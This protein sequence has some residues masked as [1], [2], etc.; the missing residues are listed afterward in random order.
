MKKILSVVLLCILLMLA[1]TGCNISDRYIVE[2]FYGVVK[3]SYI[4]ERLV[5][6]IPNIGDVEI[7]KSEMT[8]KCFDVQE[9]E[10]DYQLKAGDYVIINFRYERSWDDQ[11]VKIMEMYPAKFDRNAYLIEAEAEN[12]SFEKVDSAYIFS[13]SKNDELESVNVGDTL[14]FILHGGENGRAY[15]MLYATGEVVENKD[16]IV[17]VV[18]TMHGDE[19]DFLKNYLKMSVELSYME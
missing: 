12:I 3:Y 11:S 14:Y 7:P 2:R 17:T 19:T 6:Y 5:I 10:E 9:A 1:V 8:C 16:G 13:F 15:R 4:C 18:L